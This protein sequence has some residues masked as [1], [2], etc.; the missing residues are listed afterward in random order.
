MLI[1][2]DISIKE[3]IAISDEKVKEALSII[4]NSF[5]NCKTTSE[6]CIK[7]IQYQD[8][9]QSYYLKYASEIHKKNDKE[10]IEIIDY[11]GDLD[12]D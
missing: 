3:D 1:N 5:S 4:G 6:L 2:K 12:R 8:E 9:L 7:F 10:D 11:I